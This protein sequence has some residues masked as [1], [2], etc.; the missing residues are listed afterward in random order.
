MCILN[1]VV[2]LS[3][4]DRICYGLPFLLQMTQVPTQTIKLN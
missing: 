3:A 1:T 4:F 2:D